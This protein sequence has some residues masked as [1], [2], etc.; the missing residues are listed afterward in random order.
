[1]LQKCKVSAPF[2]SAIKIF[3]AEGMKTGQDIANEIKNQIGGSFDFSK[4]AMAVNGNPV[5]AGDAIPAAAALMIE[6][7]EA[8]NES[9]FQK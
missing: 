8:E 3:S 9:G 7:S 6:I 5:K 4:F 1:M 2:F